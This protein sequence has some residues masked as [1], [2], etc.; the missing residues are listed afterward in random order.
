MTVAKV[1]AFDLRHDQSNWYFTIIYRFCQTNAVALNPV[2]FNPIKLIYRAVL[3]V[4]IMHLA[5]FDASV[6]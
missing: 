2:C 5:T 4:W 3:H 1:A 6:I